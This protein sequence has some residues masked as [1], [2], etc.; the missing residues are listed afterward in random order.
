M[1]ITIG[2]RVKLAIDEVQQGR[3]ELALEHACIALDITSKRHYS[4][5]RSTRGLFKR[6][7][8]EYVWI[9]ELMSLGGLDIEKS[10]FGNFPLPDIPEPK[11]KDVIYHVVR[12][13]LV[14]DEG[15][16]E[17]LIFADATTWSWPRA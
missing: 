2:D 17:N 1:A 6:L 13:N 4:S 9:I 3:F 12:C 7:L 10:C 11:I 5:D 15:L 8:D 14:H 16:P